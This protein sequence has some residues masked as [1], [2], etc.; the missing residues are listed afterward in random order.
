MLREIMMTCLLLAL[1]KLA[2]SADK[3]WVL[4]RSTLTYR[5]SHPLHQ[6]EGVSQ[7]AK[8]KGVCHAGQCDF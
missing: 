3:Q 1:P 6:T 8:G 7:A 5:V 2:R 4:E